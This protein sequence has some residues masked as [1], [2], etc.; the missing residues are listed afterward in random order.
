MVVISYNVTLKCKFVKQSDV[1]AKSGGEVMWI[2][3]AVGPNAGKTVYKNS[4]LHY[5]AGGR[6]TVDADGDDN[7][8]IITKASPEDAGLFYCITSTGHHYTA[9][10]V[11]IGNSDHDTSINQLV[12][13]SYV[14]S[15]TRGSWLVIKICLIRC[16]KIFEI[17]QQILILVFYGHLLYMTIQ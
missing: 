10:L 16:F 9:Q 4:T 7:N 14:C 1:E 12:Y 13:N 6:W 3:N 17:T 15:P 2:F 11:V 5:N 8:L